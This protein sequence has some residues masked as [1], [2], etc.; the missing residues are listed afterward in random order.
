M[1]F[2]RSRPLQAEKAQQIFVIARWV[3]V[4]ERG[5]PG[6]G[7]AHVSVRARSH[8]EPQF[9]AAA[10][11]IYAVFMCG[12]PLPGRSAPTVPPLYLRTT[13]V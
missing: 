12:L 8:P 6:D 5:R 1:G 4:N 9:Y 7:G 13:S 2:R 11:R 3:V 10:L